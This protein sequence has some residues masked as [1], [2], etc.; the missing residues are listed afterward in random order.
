MTESSYNYV[1]WNKKLKDWDSWTIVLKENVD[2]FLVFDQM[3]GEI[4]E[5]EE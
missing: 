4:L 3:E 1:Y 2:M 5:N